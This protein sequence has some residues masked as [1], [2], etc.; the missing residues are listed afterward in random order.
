LEEELDL[1]IFDRTAHPVRPT[2]TGQRIIEQ[3]KVALYNVSQIKEIALAERDSCAGKVHMGVIPTV[4]PY[5]LP[6]MFSKMHQRYPQI[7][8]RVSE[9]RT[10]VIIERL[11]KAEIDMAL[12]AT[13]LDQS[14]LLE[15]PVYYEK[16]IAYVSPEDPLYAQSQINARE[17]PIDRLWVLQEGHCMRNQVF[18][19]CQT[20]SSYST[21]Y[22]AGSIDTL[23]KIVDANG[24]YTI[25]PELHQS[26]LSET[27]R[28]HIRP[29]VAPEPVREIS[30]VVREDY[31]REGLVNAIAGVVKGIIP[32]DMVDSRLKKFTIRL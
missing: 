13:P 22:E 9:M 23:V 26:L 1:K 2:E 8:L 24:G 12:L 3:A 29:F 18:N 30:L 14:D 17:M 10:S 5:V 19:F 15:I 25:I 21:I 6:R 7:E 31:V 4:A 32:E 11:R 27:Q 20:R 16:F 28:Q